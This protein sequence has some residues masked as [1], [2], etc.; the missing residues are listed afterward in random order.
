MRAGPAGRRFLVLSA[1]MGSGH[2]SAASEL[3][4]RLAAAGHVVTRA[5]VLDLLPAGLGTALRSFYR[6][7]ITHLPAVY[8]GIYA[9]FFRDGRGPR[10][11]SDPLA[12]L[13]EGRLLDLAA[14]R[15]P[16]VIVSVFHL[17]AQLSGRLRARG[18]LTAPSAVLITDFAV[19]R[20]WL[21]HGNDLYLCL[22]SEI[23]AQVERSLGRPAIA[24]GPLVDERFTGPPTAGVRS[25]RQVAE[26]GRPAALVSTG[27]WGVGTG[28][29]DT[30]GR[31]AQAGY[32]PIV[33]C[34]RS[35][36]LHRQLAAMP[37]VLA[38][39]WAGDMP[40][41]MAA[42][43]ILID[44]AAGRTALEALAAG[45]PVIGYRPIAGHGAESVRR[46]ASLGLSSYAPGPESLLRLA[47]TLSTPGPVRAQ[48]I[49]A[50]R[51]FCATD[52]A[53]GPLEA[54]AAGSGFLDRAARPALRGLAPRTAGCQ[55]SAST[56]HNDVSDR[57]APVISPHLRHRWMLCPG[58]GIAGFISFH[59]GK[60]GT[61]S[62]AGG[63][64]RSGTGS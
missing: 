2:D 64:T 11:S 18:L 27:G 14:E 53:V 20:Q 22:A 30:A 44:N 8:A 28:I 51:A 21:H 38:L 47:D 62:P 34:G 19:H 43:T 5:D 60:R 45:L 36:R 40:A 32:L 9:A 50:G 6:G 63:S 59:D 41:L 57:S 15:R 17:A 46:M 54:L 61:R 3:E 23:G 35:R 58:E 48:R 55:D 12:A 33:L 26:A 52:R 56:P 29:R 1:S 7:I 39:D 24:S 31:L 10:P 49:A 42:A 16:D 13:A 4:K 37:R 25:W